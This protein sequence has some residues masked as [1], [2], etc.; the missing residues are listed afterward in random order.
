[1]VEKTSDQ[2]KA[3][4][5]TVK[6]LRENLS[7][8]SDSG[9]R[10]R[11]FVENVKGVKN[12]DYLLRLMP[13]GGK[14]TNH[15]IAKLLRATVPEYGDGRFENLFPETTKEPKGAKSDEET[16]KGY[17]ALIPKKKQMTQNETMDREENLNEIKRA[18]KEGTIESI[19]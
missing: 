14:M 1:M 4:E 5:Q 8:I 12:N 6:K 15:L 11:I 17:G 10:T 13:T 16:K 3:F 9:Q 18:S 7:R 19:P 2:V